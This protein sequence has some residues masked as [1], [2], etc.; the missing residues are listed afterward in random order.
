MKKI[1]KIGLIVL[2]LFALVYFILRSNLLDPERRAMVARCID[3]KSEW[4]GIVD[5]YG[6]ISIWDWE[7][8]GYG[9]LNHTRSTWLLALI[10]GPDDFYV[11][12]DEIYLINRLN[13]ECG[14]G[15]NPHPYCADFQVNGESKQYSYDTAD[16]VPHYLI[17]NTKTGDQRFY[18]DLKNISA[19]EQLIFQKLR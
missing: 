8:D 5:C 19:D 18:V 2:G 15:L 7:G 1:I 6:V 12:G 17:F 11:K 9:S 13:G 10:R 14:N 4:R 16:E 3:Y